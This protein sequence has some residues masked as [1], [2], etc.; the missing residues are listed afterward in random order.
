[1]LQQWHFEGIRIGYSQSVVK[2]PVPLV[3]QGDMELVQLLFNLRGASTFEQTV[4]GDIRFCPM[5]HTVFY[6]KGFEGILQ[7][8]KGT[9]ESVVIQFAKEAFLSLMQDTTEPFQRMGEAIAKGKAVKIAPDQLHIGLPLQTALAQILRCPY[10][11]KMKRIFLYAKTLEILILQAE[12]YQNHAKRQG[13]D[14]LSAADKERIVFARDYLV[15]HLQHPPTI[16]ELARI[17]GINECKLKKGFKALFQ[18]SVFGY[19]TDYRMEMARVALLENQKTSSELSYELGYSSP[20]H[21]STAFK[22]KFGLAPGQ[23]RKR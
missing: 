14:S 11:G 12:A 23:V 10:Q 15:E 21:F 16:P 18:Q 1:V 20:Q 7:A 2:V 19:L 9:H 4:F 22:S 3:W 8:E 6:S 5:Q 13:V 17:T